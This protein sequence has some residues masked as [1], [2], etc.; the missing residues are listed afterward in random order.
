[1]YLITFD[2]DGTLVDSQ[3]FDSDLYIETIQEVLDIEIDANWGEYKHVTDSGILDQIIKEHNFE[4]LDIDIHRKV[5][6]CFVKKTKNYISRSTGSVTEISGAKKLIDTLNMRKKVIP[7]IAT[8]GW[9]ET[10]RMKLQAIGIDPDN[11]P[12]ATASDSPSR[13]E[14]MQIAEQ[15]AL[16]GST[17]HK[18]TYFGD[19]SWDKMASKQLGYHFIGIGNSVKSTFNIPNFRDLDGIFTELG[20]KP[21]H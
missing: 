15:R 7:A 18:K 3:G 11:F 9:K 14:I 5:R 4:H 12:L 21:V 8:G 2:I 17:A 16:Q 13:I 19:G 10:A 6:R 1:M 20:L